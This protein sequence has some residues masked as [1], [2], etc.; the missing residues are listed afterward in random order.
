M[1]SLDAGTDEPD[2]GWPL[3]M[4]TEAALFRFGLIGLSTLA[5]VL[6]LTAGVPT[7]A[8]ASN[9][10]AWKGCGEQLECA[11]VRVP[12]DWDKPGGRKIK[13][14]VIR[15]LASRPD[16]RIGSL[17]FNPGG[18]G[19]SGVGFVREAGEIL[20]GYGQGRFDVVSWDIRG[21]DPNVPP[22]RP[23]PVTT[24]VR[25]FEDEA[26]RTSFWEGKSIPT[27]ES[28]SR[29]YRRKIAAVCAR[30]R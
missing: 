17:F 16:E 14:A 1:D 15:H 18:P 23:G 21:S 30:L 26:S 19:N 20:D 6:L 22:D 5:G 11:K 7:S 4:T 9:E 12:L 24:P 2:A 25:C 29:R 28:E 13:L 10:I 27:T 8:G 3:L